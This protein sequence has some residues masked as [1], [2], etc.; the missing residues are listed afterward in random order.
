MEQE[1][2][3]SSFMADKARV[4]SQV[5]LSRKGSVDEAIAPLLSY[6]NEQNFFYTTSSCAGRLVLF[7][8]VLTYIHVARIKLYSILQGREKKKGC[9]WLLVSHDHLDPAQLVSK[10]DSE[11]FK[12]VSP[13]QEEVLSQERPG[14]EGYIYFKFEPFVLHVMCASLSDAKLMASIG[15]GT[16]HMVYRGVYMYRVP[17]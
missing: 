7:A 11:S 5:D 4:L 10:L 8:D 14:E 3:G 16:K 13:T 6:V 9:Q 15:G 2:S 1:A 12:G 17:L